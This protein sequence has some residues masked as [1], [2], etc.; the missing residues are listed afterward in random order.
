VS[1]DILIGK[2]LN[3]ADF[4]NPSSRPSAV[5]FI[6]SHCGFCRANAPFYREIVDAQ[7][8]NKKGMNLAVAS[9]E[10][11]A[12]TREFLTK[13]RIEADGIY[14]VS[15]A[16]KGLSNTPTLLILDE[17]GTVQRVFVGMLDETRQRQFLDAMGRAAL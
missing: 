2:K 14:Q 16:I 15:S 9:I 7:R 5:L 12:T 8:R 4:R 6:N 1:A 10:P 11:P 13:E 17:A 3:I